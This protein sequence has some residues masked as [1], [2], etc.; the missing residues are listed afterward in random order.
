MRFPGGC[1]KSELQQKSTYLPDLNVDFMEKNDIS[2]LHTTLASMPGVFVF[3]G[4]VAPFCRTGDPEFTADT[5]IPWIVF[6]NLRNQ[7]IFFLKEF[8]CGFF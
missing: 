7:Y 4:L 1:R 8:S 5:G 3:F 2:G 6:G